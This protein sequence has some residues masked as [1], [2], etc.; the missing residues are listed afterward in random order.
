MAQSDD[1]DAGDKKLQ[2]DILKLLQ[3]VQ[4]PQI[5]MLVDKQDM[6]LQQI[7]QIRILTILVLL[8]SCGFYY[9]VYSRPS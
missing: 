2:A 1:R 5:K 7:R 3:E 4:T 8:F 9:F 6:L